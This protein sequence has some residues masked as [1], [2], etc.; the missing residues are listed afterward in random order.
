MTKALSWKKIVVAIVTIGIAVA[1]IFYF[2]VSTGK[3]KPSLFVN[4]AFAEH[5]SSYTTGV[6]PSGSVLKIT[7]PNDV[8]DSTRAGEESSEKLFDFTPSIE[9][10]AFWTDKRTV[11]F[12]PAA[13]LTSGKIYAAKFFLSRIISD[14]PQELRAFEY[15]FQVIPQN[16]ELVIVNTR[17]HSKTE[18]TKQVIE[19]NL[20]TADY[21]TGKAVEKTV[22]AF[23]DGKQLNVSWTHDDDGAQHRFIVEDVVRKEQSGKVEIRADGNAIGVTRIQEVQVD[24]PPLNEFKLMNIK[25]IQS[26][27][28]YVVLQFSDPVKESQNLK[29]LITMSD[30][31]SLD[32]DV[33]NNEIWVYPP[34]LQNGSR[35]ISVGAGIRNVM[36]VK[37]KDPV[38]QEVFFEQLKPAVRFTGKGSILPS[39]DGLVVPFEA[40]NLKAVDIQILKVYENNVLQFFQ[41]NNLAGKNELRRV[42]NRILRKTI[43]L[44]NTGITDPGKWNRYTLDI[45][46]L[47][48]SEPGAIYEIKLSFKRSYSTYTCASSTEAPEIAEQF[49]VDED[50]ADDGYQGDYSYGYYEDYYDE[51]YY[52]EDFDWNQRDNP[53]HS[54]YYTSNRAVSRN[55]LASDLGMTVKRGEDG[56]TL[57]FV[58]DLKTTK[59]VV[60]VEVILYSFQLQNVGSGTTDA[61]GKILIASKEPPFAVVAKNGL[62]RG[63][64]RLANGEALH[65]SNFD[66]SG[67]VVHKGLK[68]FLYGERGVWRPGDSLYLTFILEDKRKLL[69]ANHPVVFEL[70]NPQGQVMNRIVR[71]A[72]E[73]G[74][75]NFATSTSP[76]APTGN[77]IG[78]VKVGGTAF[79]K[80]LKI[81]TVKP[82]RLK[83]NLDFGVD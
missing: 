3:K 46:K 26:P 21:A 80:A 54:S 44:E 24:I 17:P 58:T 39:T 78:K 47:I 7:F 82:N 27:T 6:I 74:F 53:C 16:F 77:W 38:S 51:Y 71:T 61:D 64:L 31:P 75:Y 68:G 57:V 22:Q 41:V 37:L 70:S 23:Q 66:V 50:P 2:T 32:F 11:E 55:I 45:S 65:I 43:T 20:N 59:P 12:R 19:G 63:Y 25:V 8:V 14:L 81:E 60:G 35:T 1:G 40:V 83:I 72:S 69:P 15:S 52:G 56:N 13:R 76:D 10:K 79:T 9:G 4:P 62:Q 28:Q 18:L 48:Q 73:N 67:E 29:G 34:V 42:G 5:I 30:L 49:Q 36:D 33:H